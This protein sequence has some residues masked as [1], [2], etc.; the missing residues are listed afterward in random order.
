MRR[1]PTTGGLVHALA[2]ILQDRRSRTGLDLL[3]GDPS[4]VAV[5]TDDE[6]LSYG[7]LRGRVGQRVGQLGGGRRLVLIEI[8]NTLQPLVT[9][10]AALAAGHVAL[11]LA[12]GSSPDLLERYDPDVVHHAGTAEL[13]HRR[14]GT[15][16]ELHP[17]LA[18]LLSTSGSTGSPKLVRLS[19]RNVESNA[20][21][22]AQYLG[23]GAADTAI[24]TLPLSYCYGLSVVNS[25]LA[26]GAGLRLTFRSVIDPE[27]WRQF[28]EAGCTSFAGVPYTF[29]LLDSTGFGDRQL[30]SLRYI[31]QAGGRLDSD[32]VRGYAQL[33]A[34]RGF[35]FVVMY[36]QTEATAR[37]AYLPPELAE[38]RAGMIG[39][40]IPGGELSVDRPNHD[41]VGELVYRG[42]NVMMGYA[43]GPPDLAL[44]RTLTELRTGDLARRHDDGLFE[45]V[46][47]ASRFV[48]LF[49]LRVDL[50]RVQRLLGEHGIEARAIGL[51]E[52]LVLAVRTPE[53]VPLAKATGSSLLGLPSHAVEA[54]VVPDFPHTSSGKPDWA[55]L[56]ALLTTR[57]DGARPVSGGTAEPPEATPEALC[58]LYA[59]LLDR[60]DA[61]VDDSFVS[62][63]GDSLSYVE[64]SLRLGDVLGRLPE[65]WPSMTMRELAGSRDPSPAKTTGPGRFAHIETSLV[66]R[67]MAIVLVTATHANLI[68][69]QGGAHLL[70]AL[71]GL[72]LARFQLA[73]PNATERSKSLLRTAAGIAVP[74]VLWIG[75]VSIVTGM[76]EPST[77]FLMNDLL[78]GGDRWTVQ[79]QFWFLEVAVWSIVGLAVAAAVP[80]LTGLEQRHPFV[81]AA[82]V[83]ALM[84]AVRLTVTGIE[85]G[86]VERYTLPATAWLVALGWVIAR[87]ASWRTRTI[88]SLFIAAALPGFFGDPLREAVVAVGLMLAVW[89]PVVPVPRFAMPA[90]RVVAASSLFVY[91][92][93]WQVYPW[94]EDDFPLLATLASFAVGIAAWQAYGLAKGGATAL[95]R[96]KRRRSLPQ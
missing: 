96:W 4:A 93:H 57:I 62:L 67:A 45:V 23:I 73:R 60:P 63:D 18:V 39:V 89:L 52:R 51:E 21:S 36:G 88:A 11:L 91:L 81:I 9:Y 90:I 87:A 66:L 95:A 75:G 22:I 58:R 48:K 31:T 43:D 41:G 2:E 54:H 65:G 24:T 49:G 71:L 46:G 25:H 27:F 53:L 50:D 30:P 6:V 17:D 47:R 61:A 70:L 16:H 82:I 69:V 8:E 29:D 33:G 74:A 79:W 59:E 77:V 28:E 85:A 13:H 56:I 12:P 84:M 83:F 35:H 10:L 1:I 40:P 15:A 26:S 19:R 94:L 5:V 32:R 3:R 34:R 37:M 55:T 64:V 72:N 68:T 86:P 78:G 92:V 14:D 76:Y 7:E 20:M 80:L 42:E 44:G 38:E